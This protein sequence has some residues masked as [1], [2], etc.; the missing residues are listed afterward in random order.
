LRKKKAWPKTVITT[1]QIESLF[2]AD[3]YARMKK[4]LEKPFWAG[5]LRSLDSIKL[6]GQSC[7]IR[8]FRD[9]LKEFVPGI[10]LSFGSVSNEENPYALKLA[11][12]YG[13]L[14]Y[15]RAR[16]SGVVKVD[17]T[18]NQ[19]FLPY[20]LVSETHE[21]REKILVNSLDPKKLSG[22]VS[23]HLLELT[24]PIRLRDSDGTPKHDFVHHC[25]PVEF[26]PVIYEEIEALYD[27]ISQDETDIIVCGEVKFFVAARPD[28]W[29]FLVVPV[30]RGEEGLLLGRDRL[31]AFEDSEWETDYFDGMK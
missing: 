10:L 28:D 11:C 20:L 2:S 22:H 8:L 21:G 31:Y 15:L 26:K 13:A 12:L 1:S 19:P 27:F 25:D 24:L 23:R 7:K 3:I 16:R 9:V 5:E 4:F 29:G 18:A 6:T 14:H 30:A 17:M